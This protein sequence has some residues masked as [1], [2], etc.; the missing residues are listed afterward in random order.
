[1]SSQLFLR[2]AV[3]V[4]GGEDGFDA[5]CRGNFLSAAHSG[6]QWLGLMPSEGTENHIQIVLAINLRI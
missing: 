1:M 6:A 5:F 2:H 4:G 3:E